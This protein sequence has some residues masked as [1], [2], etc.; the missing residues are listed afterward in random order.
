MSIAHWLLGVG[1]RH[2]NNT[3]I[4]PKTGQVIGID[5]GYSFGIG[6][7]VLHIPELVPFRTTP[8][9]LA[10]LKPFNEVGIF[11]QTMIKSLRQIRVNKD[12]II[13]LMDIFIQEPTV[14][15]LEMVQDKCDKREEKCDDSLW[16]PENCLKVARDKLNGANSVYV[17]SIELKNNLNVEIKEG[18]MRA[19]EDLGIENS[20]L[21][22]EDQVDCLLKHA[23]D[24]NLLG[25]MH[26]NWH[27]F[28]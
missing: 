26:C 4:S 21:D 23:M 13:S 8:Q 27:S 25:R 11:K 6:T 7:Q 18:Y 12:L 19:L 14:N 24:R 20:S 15:W 9:I 5:F 16:T 22:V 1:D 3:L 10:V 2:L 17:T 28:V